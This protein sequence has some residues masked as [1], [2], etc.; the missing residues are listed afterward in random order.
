MEK[1]DRVLYKDGR[2]EGT[3]VYTF[4]ETRAFVL[5][6]SYVKDDLGRH[7]KLMEVFDSDVTR[8]EQQPDRQAG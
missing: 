7:W 8:I 5:F 3:V 6:D 4:S 2:T 1:G